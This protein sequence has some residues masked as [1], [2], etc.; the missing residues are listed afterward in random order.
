[1]NLNQLELLRVL[2]ET[3]YNQSKAAQKMNVVQSAASR[4]LQLLEDE[5]G[6]PLFER[7]GKKLLGL[8]AL[9]ERIM[10]EVERINLSKMNIQSIAEDFR[11]NRNGSLRIA[12]THTQAKYL[13]PEPIRLFREKYPAFNISM[14]QSSPDNLIESLHHHHADIA[15]CTEKLD[16]DEKLVVKSCYEWHHVAIVPKNH[17]LA[18]G[19]INLNKI[20]QYPILTYLPGFT[21]R[22]NIEKA[23]KNAGLPL[24]I[25]LSAADSDIIKTYVKL[26]LGVGIIA[27]MAYDS[28]VD[29][30]LVEIDLTHLIKRSVTKI[31]YLKQLYLPDYLQYFINELINQSSNLHR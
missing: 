17:P 8:T 15:I 5:L 9:G 22:S 1:M 28:K 20:S 25:T 31:A 2:K 21:G 3:Q 6:A 30:D 16:E 12:T 24:N 27:S 19:E 13:L 14:V 23:F 4:Q 10:E 26:G 11:D 18:I 7:Y 29:T